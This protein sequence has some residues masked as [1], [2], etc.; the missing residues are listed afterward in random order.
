[1]DWL[2]LRTEP[3][4]PSKALT[5]HLEA[6]NAEGRSFSTPP[7]VG[8]RLGNGN[9]PSTRARLEHR[10][11][12]SIRGL[13]PWHDDHAAAAALPYDSLRKLQVPSISILGEKERKQR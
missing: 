7:K 2:G 10:P 13:A 4:Q 8:Q 11:T 3:F 1:M 9:D 5:P 6:R 12:V